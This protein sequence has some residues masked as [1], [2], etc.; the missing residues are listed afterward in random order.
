MQRSH[1]FS[2]IARS[3]GA[4]RDLSLRPQRNARPS[5]SDTRRCLAGRFAPAARRQLRMRCSDAR[6]DACCATLTPNLRRSW[7]A[8]T[9]RVMPR[10][11]SSLLASIGVPAC[12]NFG[13][14][15]AARRSASNR[16][17]RWT[18]DSSRC[19]RIDQQGITRLEGPDGRCPCHCV[20]VRAADSQRATPFF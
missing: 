14:G 11:G 13:R 20:V 19:T 5:S 8:L 6:A 3:D 2:P 10:R 18:V 1:R 17:P 15:Y 16:P 12:A 9:C 4:R 7:L